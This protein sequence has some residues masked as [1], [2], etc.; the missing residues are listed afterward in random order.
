MADCSVVGMRNVAGF[1]PHA[2]ARLQG[3][4]IFSDVKGWVS[5]RGTRFINA[6][7]ESSKRILPRFLDQAEKN[8]KEVLEQPDV[9]QSLL[10]F[11]KDPTSSKKKS[12]AWQIIDQRIGPA[13]QKEAED[14]AGDWVKA[15]LV[16][17]SEHKDGKGLPSKGI[18]SA[19]SAQLEMRVAANPP[20]LPKKSKGGALA[21]PGWRGRGSESA[22]G[23]LEPSAM[24]DMQAAQNLNGLPK[25][26]D[27]K[28]RSKKAWAVPLVGGGM[29]YSV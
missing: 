11:A 27:S 3:E 25:R 29:K 9:R 13:V 10:N 26:K 2:Y 7:E 21:P 24:L 20:K 4:G 6:V 12:D 16:S 18:R 1:Q 15:A 8:V 23:G 28:T 19:P 17:A 22:G 5:R 14:V